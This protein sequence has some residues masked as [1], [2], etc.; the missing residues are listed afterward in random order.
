[1]KKSNM[2]KNTNSNVANDVIVMSSWCCYDVIVFHSGGTVLLKVKIMRMSN[3]KKRCHCKGTFC[4][5]TYTVLLYVGPA[6]TQVRKKYPNDTYRVLFWQAM[7]T[8]WNYTHWF[9]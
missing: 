8:L 7:R 5:N 2:Q 6:Q 4:T 1:M 3:L 9:S